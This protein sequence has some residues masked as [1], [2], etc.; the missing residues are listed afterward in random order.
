V[1]LDAAQASEAP[2][3]GAQAPPV[4]Q[5]DA[6]VMA[7]HHVLHVAAPVDQHADLPAGLGAELGEV[8]GELVGDQAVRRDAPPEQVLE[9]LDLAGLEAAGI[10]E[11][12]D[13][14]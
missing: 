13:G 9:L 5:L 3:A 14:G 11:D 12:L 6:A 2:P 10:A 4:G 7:D 1:R 8:A